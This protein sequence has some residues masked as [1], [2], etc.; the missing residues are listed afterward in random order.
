M[1][2]A[3]AQLLPISHISRAGTGAVHMAMQ[4]TARDNS[5]RLSDAVAL[6]GHLGRHLLPGSFHVHQTRAE[7][8][9]FAH[10]QFRCAA[11]VADFASL[12]RDE[13]S[14]CAGRRSQAAREMTEMLRTSALFPK[15]LAIWLS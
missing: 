2:R 6:Q 12:L 4:I 7:G 3:E 9:S 5:P 13:L 8:E 10:G 14:V 11:L 1:S 15:G